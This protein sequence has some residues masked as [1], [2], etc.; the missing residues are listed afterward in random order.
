MYQSDA[1]KSQKVCKELIASGKL[2]SFTKKY[3]NSDNT[4]VSPRGEVCSGLLKYSYPE[5]P[6]YRQIVEKPWAI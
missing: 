3:V 6:P 4:L 1:P 5:P 2:R